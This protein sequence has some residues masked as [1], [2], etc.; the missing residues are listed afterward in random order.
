MLF[1]SKANI[2]ALKNLGVTH[3]LAISAVGI[4]NEQ[5]KPGDMIL[6]NQVIDMTKGIRDHTFFRKGVVGHSMFADP[7][8]QQF[9]DLVFQAAEKNV[10]KAHKDGTYV[11]IEGPRFSTRAESHFYRKVMNPSCIGMTAM[12]EASLAREAEMSYALLGLA[13]DY[14]CWHES[15]DDV[16]VEAVLA[17]LKNNVDTAKN[18]IFELV[19][20]FSESFPAPY[21]DSGR[22]MVVTNP[23]KI[24]TEANEILEYLYGSKM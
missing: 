10:N 2:A 7:F 12:P 6:P 8:C 3:I 11:C 24:P 1:R 13:T 21:R 18:I 22:S 9:R 20:G 5:I 19:K 17:I 23:E 14:D 4:M 15:E 16:T